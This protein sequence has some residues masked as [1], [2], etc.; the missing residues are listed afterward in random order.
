MSEAK[1]ILIIEPNE[2][3]AAAITDCLKPLKSVI[4]IRSNIPKSYIE[5]VSIVIADAYED[6][7]ISALIKELRKIFLFQP[8]IITSHGKG[9]L[10]KEVR[11]D[12]NLAAMAK[13]YNPDDL[14]CVVESM[15][16]G[17]PIAGDESVKLPNKTHTAS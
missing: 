6:M 10:C 9:L 14:R 12:K 8:I 2:M 5:S 3:H 16:S 15:I 17:Q 4:V 1:C 7:T 11:E 13:P